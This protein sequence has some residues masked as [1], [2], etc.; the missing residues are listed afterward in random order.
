M[1][2]NLS[3]FN[4]HSEYYYD[5]SIK[6][7][8]S[9]IGIDGKY[10]VECGKHRTSIAKALNG[11]DGLRFLHN[12][13]TVNYKIDHEFFEAYNKL[14]LFINKRKYWSKHITISSP[15]YIKVEEYKD[16]RL[17]IEMRK[18]YINI[19]FNGQ[20]E[21]WFLNDIKNFLAMNVIKKILLIFYNLYFKY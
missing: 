18:L 7:H 6:D 5:N 3:L 20:K 4:N 12:V 21:K 8:T 2:N 10:F 13:C 16:F 19:S 1:K 11:I 17:I 15:E 14:F 9:Y